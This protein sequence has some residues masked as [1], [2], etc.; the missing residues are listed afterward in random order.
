MGKGEFPLWHSGLMIS[1]FSVEPLVCSLALYSGLKIWH[2][3]S[4]GTGCSS[5]LYSIPNP[6]TSL[7]HG[8]SQNRHFSKKGLQVTN[9]YMKMC[10]TSKQNLRK[11]INK[12][13]YYGKPV[14]KIAIK[15]LLS[16]TQFRSSRRGAVVNESD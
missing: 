13:Q 8:C 6:G 15:L 9:R 1:L 4:C 16:K 14:H 2:C 12:T 7:C 10:S 3:C 11:M 5:G